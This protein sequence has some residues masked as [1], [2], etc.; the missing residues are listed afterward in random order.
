MFKDYY[1]NNFKIDLFQSIR[2][3]SYHHEFR[4]IHVGE[5][6]WVDVSELF[7][8]RANSLLVKR[9]INENTFFP[10]VAIYFTSMIP[11]V[12]MHIK[13]E[14]AMNNF[15]KSSSWPL[16]SCGLGGI[17]DPI[18]TLWE[19][20]LMPSKGCDVKQFIDTIKEGEKIITADVIEFL[21]GGQPN[22]NENAYQRLV[23]SMDGKIDKVEE[24]IHD[25]VLYFID[26]ILAPTLN[27]SPESFLYNKKK[28]GNEV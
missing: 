27:K 28:Y 9:M 26:W 8:L 14:E 17:M 21:H 7:G 23:D 25:A 10:S 24:C 12:I 20:N 18:H 16:I 6:I 5:V 11:Q 2:N 15:Y 19:A 13:D 22:V 3:N 4:Q 1:Y